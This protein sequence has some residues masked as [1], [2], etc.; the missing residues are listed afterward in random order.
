M[1][2]RCVLAVG[3][4]LGLWC[5]RVDAQQFD[6]PLSFRSLHPFS[7]YSASLDRP[8]AQAFPFS[9]GFP[10][11]VVRQNDF[12]PSWRPTGWD[13]M[14]NLN[15]AT[16]YPQARQTRTVGSAS[17]YSDDPSKEAPEMRKSVFDYVHGEVGF[18]YGRSSGGRNSFDTEGGYIYTETGNER[19]SIGVGASYENTNFQF[20][21]KGR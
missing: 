10:W 17:P 19:F 7:A 4:F 15:F 14:T 12:L 21:R 5:T 3:V 20:S 11:S 9:S 2:K 18:F 13:S 6:H 8:S 16:T 1:T